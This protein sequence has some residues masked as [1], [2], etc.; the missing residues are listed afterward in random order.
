MHLFREKFPHITISPVPTLEWEELLELMKHTNQRYCS[1]PHS[2]YK[3]YY[4]E[5]MVTA[6]RYIE[7]GVFK[8]YGLV[9]SINGKLIPSYYV[10]E[11]YRNT[12][13]FKEI[14][15]SMHLIYNLP[16]KKER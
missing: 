6:F 14:W 15:K 4:G 11:E 2:L 9:E 3:G 5:R 10:L 8:G 16:K 1:G 7:D 12:K 13:V